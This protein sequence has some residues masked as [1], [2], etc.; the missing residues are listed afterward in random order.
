MIYL[1]SF[2]FVAAACAVAAHIHSIAGLIFALVLA[3]I[4]LLILPI[5]GTET[6]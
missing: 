6:D 4:S 2:F 3:A 1:V 5:N